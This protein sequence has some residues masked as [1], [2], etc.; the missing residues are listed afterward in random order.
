MSK[1]HRITRYDKS[2]RVSS[3]WSDQCGLCASIK[4]TD[5]LTVFRRFW[6]K[7]KF[8]AGRGIAQNSNDA[9]GNDVEHGSGYSGVNVEYLDT[10][11]LDSGFWAQVHM[12]WH[13]AWPN[14][15]FISI[16]SQ[17][18]SQSELQ[19]EFRVAV[20]V[21][22]LIFLKRHWET[23]RQA[24]VCDFLSFLEYLVLRAK[25]AVVVV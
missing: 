2:Y 4:G 17:P 21:A 3:F 23:G 7:T 18:E 8:V 14:K 22:V 19:S 9:N 12:I 5:C 25:G 13:L 10:F 1:Y 20:A 11:L 16:D 6:N 24:F 15:F